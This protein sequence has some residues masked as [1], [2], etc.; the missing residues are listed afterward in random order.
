MYVC[1]F[2]CP[3]F[4]GLAWQRSISNTLS[5]QGPS[6]WAFFTFFPVFLNHGFRLL[7]ANFYCLK[8]HFRPQGKSHSL[9]SSGAVQCGAESCHGGRDGTQ[10]VD[11]WW[12]LPRRWLQMTSIQ[13]VEYIPRSSGDLNCA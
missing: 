3:Y 9:V 2:V 8:L 12:P 4:H 1:L 13:E 11:V 10:T 6:L 5:D 7:S